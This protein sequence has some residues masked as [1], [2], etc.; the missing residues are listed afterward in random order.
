MTSIHTHVIADTC[1]ETC[2]S[3]LHSFKQINV[4]DKLTATCTVLGARFERLHAGL[5]VSN[6]NNLFIICFLNYFPFFMT[7]NTSY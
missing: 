2:L 7:I 1:S 6:I 4:Y 3:F 5:L